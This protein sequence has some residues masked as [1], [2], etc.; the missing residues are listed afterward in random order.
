MI[1]CLKCKDTFDIN[2]ENILP[3][4]K[5]GQ[6]IGWQHRICPKIEEKSKGEL[7]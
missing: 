3:I 2:D 4:I 7:K 5:D 1:V 6:T